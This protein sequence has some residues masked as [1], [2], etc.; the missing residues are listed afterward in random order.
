MSDV[1]L[2]VF[3]SGG[4]DSS[5]I[6]ATMAE[7]MSE[8]VKTFSVG[9]ESGY[10]SEFDFAREV[11]TAIGADHHQVVLVPNRLFAN[12]PRLIWHEDEPV[13]N[14]S[15]VALFEVAKLAQSQVKVVL[16]GEGSDELFAG[17][18]RYWATLFNSKWGS[19]YHHWMPKWLQNR[20]IRGTLWQWPLP[21][22]IKK[23]LSHTF[24]NH[25][26]CPEEIVYDNWHAVFPPHVHPRLFTPETWNYVRHV[27]PYQET[28]AH[29]RSRDADNLL[30]QLLFT[31]QKTYLVEL[32]R[33]Q[34]TMSMA[35]SIESRV[36]FLDHHLVEFA[37][38]V[39]NRYKVRGTQGKY[40]VKQAMRQ[41]LPD[42]IIDRKKMGFPVPI[43]QW[44]R[45]GFDRVFR[46]VLVCD[47][48]EEHGIFNRKYIEELLLDHAA[49]KRDNT[50]ALWTMLNFELWTRIFI[51]GD[52]HASVASEM[53]ETLTKKRDRDSRSRRLEPSIA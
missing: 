41:L 45:N 37:S 27:A 39:P 20:C 34:D 38:R 50:D 23:R 12:L 31:D 46:S 49:G 36:P 28:M 11:A 15:S 48:T 2:G 17:Y 47:R 29:F 35:A 30:D 14:A 22:S 18:E 21:L 32:L 33:K 3:L 5:A 25:S 40:L 1:P 42:S 16:T 52:G 13:R 8:P 9:F 6:A 10:Y 24:L 4:L 44:L 53:I 26:P 43:N 7:Q 51:D 19:A